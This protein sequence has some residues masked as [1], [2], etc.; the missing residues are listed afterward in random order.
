MESKFLFQK[1]KL[2]GNEI[3]IVK[4]SHLSLDSKRFSQYSNRGKKSG[5]RRKNK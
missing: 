4:N 5:E 2:Q 1:P 3:L